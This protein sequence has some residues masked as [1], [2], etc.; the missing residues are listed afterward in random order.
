[1]HAETVKEDLELYARYTL[2]GVRIVFRPTAIV[3]AQEARSLNQ[4]R[5]QRLRWGTGKWYIVRRFAGPLIASRLRIRQR[6]DALAE[7]THQGPIL[8]SAAAVT[9]AAPLLGQS[10]YLR[11]L[12]LTLLGT[13]LPIFIWTAMSL[14]RQPDPVRLLGALA[15]VPLYTIWRLGVFIFAGVRSSHQRWIRSPRQSATADT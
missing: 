11:V 9:L 8:H 14:R 1:M 7:I 3:Y 6:L 13:V 4:A 2:A 5:T 12:G 15:C 10:G